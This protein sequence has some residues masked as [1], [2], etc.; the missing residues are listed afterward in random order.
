MVALGL[1][2]N[3]CVVGRVTAAVTLSI[4]LLLIIG[5]GRIHLLTLS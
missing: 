2:V 1:S 3:V 4:V 5:L